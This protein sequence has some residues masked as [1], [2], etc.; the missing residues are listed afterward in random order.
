M[1][2]I[3]KAIIARLKKGGEVFEV[4]VDCD[5]AMEFRDGKC[6]LTDV[7]ATEAIYKDAKKGDK[8]SET[9][10]EKLFETEDVKKI[11][12]TIVIKGEIHLT[13]EHRSQLREE[14]RKAI[15]SLIHRNA[16]DS[17]TKLPHPP[18]RIE[19]AM[20]EARVNID[21]LKSAEMQIDEVLN[22]I[23]NVLP[24]K[25][26]LVEVE[27]KIPAQFTGSAYGTI[28]QMGKVLKENWEN[29]GSLTLE[30]EIPGGLQEELFD[31]LNNLTHGGIESRVIKEKE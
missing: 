5:K 26:V 4:L 1:I 3:N 30:L 18:N 17:K 29:N 15:V 21:E 16:I 19:S 6:E 11:A 14:K 28:K 10:M 23:R 20:E 8:A 25:F 24:I 13:A 7:L 12:E 9:E 22:K 2:D 31:K 27:I